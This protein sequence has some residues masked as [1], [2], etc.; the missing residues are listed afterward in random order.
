M[1]SLI[2]D[3]HSIC[4]VCRGVDCVTDHWCPECKDVGDSVMTKYVVH[5]LSLQRKLQ[6][7]HR[8][9]DLAPAPVVVADV[10]VTEP[11][12]SQVPPSITLVSP[13]PVDDSSQLSG[14]RGEIL[15]QDK[16][17]FDSF[18]QS[19][20]ARFTSLD[21]RFS[22]VT[23]DASK[24]DDVI[25]GSNDVSQDVL[26]VPFAAPS[27][28]AGRC[29]PTPD[30]APFAPCSVGLGTTLGGPVTIEAPTSGSPQSCLSF[31]D[32]LITLRVLES[33]GGQC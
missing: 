26:T 8:K 32:A 30:R 12:S 16:S 7:K 33:L 15:C 28:V 18:V 2:H 29:E 19:L 6:S 5:K 1:S 25:S 21:N 14:V 9:K 23:S 10:A 31:E 27:I 3:F 13:V 20:E 17:S 22:H 11:P 4:V 24:V